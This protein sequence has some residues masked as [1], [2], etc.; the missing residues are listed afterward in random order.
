MD[1]H[2]DEN[3]ISLGS[4]VCHIWSPSLSKYIELTSNKTYGD[5]VID[6][7]DRQIAEENGP[8]YVELFLYK[9]DRRF[10]ISK[11]QECVCCLLIHSTCTKKNNAYVEPV[12]DV[13][14]FSRK[15]TSSN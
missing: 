8:L 13:N 5:F 3:S 14:N 11:V 6:T 9:F 10:P 7:K 12:T 4:K 2:I 15:K 1:H